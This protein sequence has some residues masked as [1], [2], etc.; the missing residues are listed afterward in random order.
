MK[1]GLCM[2][3]LTGLI[4]ASAAR[5]QESQFTASN[6]KPQPSL[7]A[8]EKPALSLAVVGSTSIDEKIPLSTGRRGNPFTNVMRTGALD[9]TQGAKDMVTFRDPHFAVGAWS[10]V[11]ATIA[12]IKTTRDAESRC[13]SCFEGGIIFRN[14]RPTTGQLIALNVPIALFEMAGAHWLRRTARPDSRLERGEWLIPV[15]AMDAGH[16][17]AAILNSRQK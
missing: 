8:V 13:P 6:E 14:G 3:V 4:F 12:D 15:L 17:I 2:C 1:K 10:M 7:N 9:L 5:A 16:G 11:F